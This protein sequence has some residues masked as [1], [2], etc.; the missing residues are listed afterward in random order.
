MLSMGLCLTSLFGA[1]V[2]CWSQQHPT[3]PPSRGSSRDCAQ[4]ADATASRPDY[5]LDRSEEDWSSLCNPA[6]RGKDPWDRLKYIALG[7]SSYISFGGEFRA[8]YERYFN[9]N[10][11]SGPQD[12]NGYYLN[13]LIGHTDMHLGTRVRVFAE[14]QSGL[15]F[16]RNGGPRPVVD[17]DKLDVSQLFLELNSS[18]QKDTPAISLRLGRQELNYG[19]G[20]L[21]S[22]RELNVRRPFD[23][24]KL[25]FRPPNWRIDV[26]AVKPV[27]TR[28]G[29][30]DDP[31]DHGQTLWGVWA[32][33]TNGPAFVKK[34]DFYYL[35]L[36]RSNAR[37]E[38]G[39]ARERRNTLGVNAHEEAGSI[40]FVQEAD[41][42]LG[43]F[44]SGRL[45]AWKFAQEVSYSLSGIR[46]RPT[47]GLQGAI[48][49]GGGSP[50]NADLQTFYPLFPKGLYYG[51]MLFTSGSL[52]AIVVHPTASFQL[53]RKISINLDN[54]FFW[55]ESTGDGIYSQ[56][57]IFLR[58]GQ[59]SRARYVGATQDLS[60][61]WQVDRHTTLQGLAAYYE[62]GSYLRETQPAGNNAS[63]FSVTASYRF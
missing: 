54:F 16:G 14:L 47:F 31:P 51:Y 56:S 5:H 28:N 41:L 42:Q 50:S 59:A 49:S 58:S 39:T 43:T 11:G 48:S 46:Y 44:G 33:T 63:Y 21:V 38:N 2:P 20:T 29:Y 22:T 7:R 40:T 6:V 18:T 1:A 8:S 60:V 37:F 25:M 61:V 4:V 17:Q 62:V 12:P 36:D 55:R 13:R 23:G 19:E 35:G 57:G 15:E 26:F 34:L 3:E 10:W 27:A 45:T 32:T 9:Y 24:I 52:N 30:F 53:S